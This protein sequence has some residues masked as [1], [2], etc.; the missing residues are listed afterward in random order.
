MTLF[1]YLDLS[2]GLQYL[3]IA[4]SIMNPCV[5]KPI[6]GEEPSSS[7]HPII[8]LLAKTRPPAHE[9]WGKVPD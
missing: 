7:K 1:L 5:V 6:P 9:P 4:R 8:A 2:P 3:P